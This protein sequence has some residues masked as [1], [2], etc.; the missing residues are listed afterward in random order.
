[1]YDDMTQEFVMTAISDYHAHLCTKDP[2]PNHLMETSLLDASW[3][4]ACKVTGINLSC[5][6]QLARL[7]TSHGSQVHGQL[8]TKLHPLVEAM[9]GFHSSQSKNTIKKNW[10]L[11]EGLK[12]DT[13]FAFKEDGQHNFLK[14]PLIQKIINTMWFTNKHDD[15]VMFHDYFK[16]FPYPALALVLTAIKCCIDEWVMGT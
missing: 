11:A 7:V 10:A 14:V 6:P 4:Q 9:F 13:N 16:P 15:S 1:D 8:K 5:T 12:E 3:A 2:M